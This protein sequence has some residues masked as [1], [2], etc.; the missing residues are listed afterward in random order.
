[1]TV[2]CLVHSWFVYEKIDYYSQL[3]LRRTPIGPD[4]AAG[5]LKV[6]SVLWRVQLQ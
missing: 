3:F 2:K 1:M 5:Y 4:P 6:A